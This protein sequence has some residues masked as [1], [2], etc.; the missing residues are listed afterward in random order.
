MSPRL[1]TL[2]LVD[3]VHLIRLLFILAYSGNYI[4]HDCERSVKMTEVQ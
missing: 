3:A 2:K 1:P 4:R